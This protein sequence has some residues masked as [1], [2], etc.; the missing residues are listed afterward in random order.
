MNRRRAD[1]AVVAVGCGVLLLQLSLYLSG[2]HVGWLALIL[3]AGRWAH[4]AEHNQAH[5]SVFDGRVCSNL[6]EMVL[7]LS[8]A[9]PVDLY[10]AHHVETHHRYD[11]GP[12]DWTSPFAYK[13][14]R[15]PDRPVHFVVY[16]A[17]FPGRAW[18]RGVPIVWSKRERQTIF[19]GSV[20]VLAIFAVALAT[21]R[22]AEFVIFFLVPWVLLWLG[23]AV[24][25]WLHHDGRSFEEGDIAND[26]YG[27]LNRWIAFNIGYHS[28]HHRYPSAHWSA[29]PLLT[30]RDRQTDRS[31]PQVQ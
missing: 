1:A 23:T 10:R 4:L 14:A 3:F 19:L 30:S 17:T 16:V 26:N 8:T 7:T 18:R 20:A 15:F 28:A 24:A 5:K 6:F 2:A 11:N 21:Y 9:V 22:T 25:N 13:G 29:L 27:F 31:V 12:G